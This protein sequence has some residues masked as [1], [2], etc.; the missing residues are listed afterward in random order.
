MT[1]AQSREAWAV[2]TTLDQSEER[3]RM[4]DDSRA[5]WFLTILEGTSYRC[6]HRI[7][8]MHITPPTMGATSDITVLHDW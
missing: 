4:P 2:S 7:A 1:L 5:T 8:R 3:V 6:L